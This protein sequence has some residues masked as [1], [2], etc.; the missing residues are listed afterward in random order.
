MFRDQKRKFT[1]PKIVRPRRLYWVAS[2]G[3]VVVAMATHINGSQ[4]QGKKSEENA[5]SPSNAW[6]LTIQTG[7]SAPS[8]WE[9]ELKRFTS[10]IRLASVETT[11][12]GSAMQTV[13]RVVP[14]PEVSLPEIVS[15]LNAIP[16]VESVAARAC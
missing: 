13:Y 15:A 2:I 5:A 12:R 1:R 3:T 7:L 16:A 11:R 6:K 4:Q 8:G 9:A 14:K 10:E